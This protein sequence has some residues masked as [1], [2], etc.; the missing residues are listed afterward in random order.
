MMALTRFP[1]SPGMSGVTGGHTVRHCPLGGLCG[2]VAQDARSF[3][4]MSIRTT[5]LALTA[6]AVGASMATAAPASAGGVGDFL[7]PAFA[8]TCTNDHGAHANGVTTRGTGAGDGN[9]AGLPIGSPA[10]HCGGAGADPLSALGSAAGGLPVGL[11][12]D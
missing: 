11:N 7:S 4:V 12:T 1:C 5:G 9:L 10:N 8:T 3:A 6:I 2:G